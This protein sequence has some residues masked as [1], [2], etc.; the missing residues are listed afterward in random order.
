MNKAAAFFWKKM[1]SRIFI[2]REDKSMPGSRA[3][4]ERL[5]G[6]NGAGDIK[7]KLILAHLPFWTS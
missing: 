3:S 1:S 6:A 5:I 7:L 2:A 4:K